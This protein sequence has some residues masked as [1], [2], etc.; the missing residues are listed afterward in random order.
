M[1]TLRV[2]STVIDGGRWPVH[3]NPQMTA[4]IFVLNGPSLNLLG[5]REPDIYGPKRSTT[6]PR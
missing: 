6:S 4:T 2:S 1:R 5:T 3:R